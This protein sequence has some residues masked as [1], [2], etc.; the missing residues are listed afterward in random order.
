MSDSRRR[1]GSPVRALQ[2]R[3]CPC[4]SQRTSFGG[5]DAAAARSPSHRETHSQDTSRDTRRPRSLAELRRV[6]AR[7][8][9]RYK[10]RTAIDRA[11]HLPVRDGQSPRWTASHHGKPSPRCA[12]RRQVGRPSGKSSRAHRH[13][14][15]ACRSRGLSSPTTSAL[16]R[17]PEDARAIARVAGAVARPG[18]HRTVRTLFVY[19]SSGRRVMTP[20]A[21]RLIDLES[22][23]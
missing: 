19:G 9:L 17:G 13:D 21:G 4:G 18:S 22:S 10:L 2:T 12:H 14:R 3:P 16:V 5:P 15:V 11:P 1:G 8:R 6:R 20:A 23:P 7:R